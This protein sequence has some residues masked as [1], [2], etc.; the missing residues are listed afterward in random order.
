MH[1]HISPDNAKDVFTGIIKRG[2]PEGNKMDEKPNS[3]EISVVIPVYNEE[4]NL[5]ELCARLSNVFSSITG[6][7]EII[8]VDDGSTGLTKSK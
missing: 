7:H 3:A 5:E 6:N 8:F 1:A 4:E 2:E